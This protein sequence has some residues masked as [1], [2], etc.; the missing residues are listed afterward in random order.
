MKKTNSAT[1]RNRDRPS[2]SR[3]SIKLCTAFFLRNHFIALGHVTI[4]D[5]AAV[6]EPERNGKHDYR[7]D[8]PEKAP[9]WSG[10]HSQ[11]LHHS[12]VGPGSIRTAHPGYLKEH[13]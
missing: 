13:L 7:R 9:K 12:G 11:L 10:D 2:Q 3:A 1:E 8:T 6:G 4:Y 5:A